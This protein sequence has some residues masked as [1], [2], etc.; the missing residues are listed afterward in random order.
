[1]IYTPFISTKKH[2]FTLEKNGFNKKNSEHAE[3]FL[4]IVCKN[5]ISLAEGGSTLP[6]HLIADMPAKQSIFF[7]AL[8]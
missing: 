8:P 1:M 6:S 7:K 3:Y 2:K 4:H 5:S